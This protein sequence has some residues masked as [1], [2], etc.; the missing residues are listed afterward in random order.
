MTQRE[1][2]AQLPPTAVDMLVELSGRRVEAGGVDD[3]GVDETG[4][5]RGQP[6]AGGVELGTQAIGEHVRRGLGGAVGIQRLQ[7]GVGGHRRHVDD[8]SAGAALDQTPPEGPTAVH[9]TAEVDV[10]HAVEL[11]GRGVQEVP[12]LTDAGVVDDDVRQPVFRAD[13]LGK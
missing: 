11:L 13:P 10:Q 6:N 12:G 4:A 1:H 3:V 7:R 2:L 9:H 8:V 5:D